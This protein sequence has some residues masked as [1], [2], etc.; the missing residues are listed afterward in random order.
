[1]TEFRPRPR[2]KPKLLE[3]TAGCRTHDDIAITDT[4]DDD[5]IAITPADLLPGLK[6]AAEGG[7]DI[8]I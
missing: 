4:A 3:R 1:M 7:L 2:G 6:T 8:R 5:D